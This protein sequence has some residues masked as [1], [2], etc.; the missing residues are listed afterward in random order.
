MNTNVTSVRPLNDTTIAGQQRAASTVLQKVLNPFEARMEK[1]FM[2][3]RDKPLLRG[4]CNLFERNLTFDLD[5]QSYVWGDKMRMSVEL[6]QAIEASPLSENAKNDAVFWAILFHCTYFVLGYQTN[7]AAIKDDTECQLSH[8]AFTQAVLQQMAALSEPQPADAAHWQG[9]GYEFKPL[10]QIQPSATLETDVL[11]QL[12]SG[13]VSPGSITK[14]PL[15]MFS[16]LQGVQGA[17]AE[18]TPETHENFAQEMLNEWMAEFAKT[19][20]FGEGSLNGIRLM[21]FKSRPPRDASEAIMECLQSRYPVTE[22]VALYN[23]KKLA[24][25]YFAPRPAE[26]VKEQTGH[27]MKVFT[28]FFQRK[29]KKMTYSINTF[30]T[31]ILSRIEV[32]EDED[33]NGKLKELAILGGGG[34]DF[35]CIAAKVQEL[36]DAGDPGPNGKPYKSDLAIVFTDLAGCFPDTVPCDFVWITTTRDCDLGAVASVNIPGT[37]IYL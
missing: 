25:D 16:E 29:K 13:A 27:C 2:A 1:A 7:L 31:S 22:D 26:P 28:D 36:T 35:R 20:T 17:L 9:N 14:I 3:H 15:L 8:T 12:K 19:N 21:Y 5:R 24:N 6:L 10:L 37:V 4:F 33:P 18:Y 11:D 30:D 23:N 32:R 34:T